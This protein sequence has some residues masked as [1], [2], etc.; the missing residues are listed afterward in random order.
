MY[1][2]FDPAIPLVGIS[3]QIQACVKGPMYKAIHRHLV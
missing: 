1:I 2:V 3:P